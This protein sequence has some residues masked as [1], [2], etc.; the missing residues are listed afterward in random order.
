MIA[1]YYIYSSLR[2]KP[3]YFEAF[4]VFLKG[5]LDIQK[6]KAISQINS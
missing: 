5:K 2:E 6:S 3:Y 1:K 4:L